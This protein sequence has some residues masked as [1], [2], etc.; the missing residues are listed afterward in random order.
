M[1]TKGA[2]DGW[3]DDFVFDDD[4]VKSAPVHEGGPL[5]KPSRKSL[6][7]VKREAKRRRRE[8]RRPAKPP[9]PPKPV[10]S[11]SSSWTGKG[12]TLMSTV[13][14]LVVVGAGGY[15]VYSDQLQSPTSA[16]E[17]PAL[18]D[19]VDP[20]AA[21]EQR[22]L[23]RN[24]DPW[25]GT[26]ASEWPRGASGIE[27]PKARVLAPYS[28]ADVQQ[29]LRNAERYLETAILDERVVYHGSVKPVLAT[30]EDAD[31]LRGEY[32]DPETGKYWP[33]LATR[34][35]P[36]VLGPVGDV[37]R[38]NGDMK[39]VL[40]GQ[41]LVV[42]FSYSVAYAVRQLKEPK[43]PPQLIVVRREGQ[44]AFYYG[45]PGA[46]G[47]PYPENL[48]HV[49]DHSVCGRKWPFPAYTTSWM[50]RSRKPGDK[51]APSDESH[52]LTDPKDS[53]NDIKGCFDNTGSL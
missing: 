23:D 44:L 39:P 51:T 14:T 48:R 45:V 28:A 31:I 12:R 9:K 49:S 50:D 16:A 7:E 22:E 25:E 34:F 6:R 38:V 53:L 35:R 26:G 43:Q 19:P 40:R 30:I 52:D 4:F 8:A 41:T 13:L 29:A 37:I 24:I 10:R 11:S 36:N 17:D 2:D 42:R 46:V 32:G 18:A 3:A 27:P 5:P 47:L 15:L 21:A 33:A 20:N 1:G